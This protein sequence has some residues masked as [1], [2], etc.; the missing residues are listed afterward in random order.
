MRISIYIHDQYDATLK[1]FGDINDVTDRILKYCYDNNIDI[2]SI[3]KPPARDGARRMEINVFNEDYLNDYSIAPNSPKFS[4]RKILYWFVDNTI[5]EELDWKPINKF[6]DKKLALI[7]KSIKK[8]LNEIGRLQFE[9]NDDDVD[10]I[11]EARRLI[12][13]LENKYNDKCNE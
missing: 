13:N 4:L 7:N 3:P 2:A 1:M 11:K 12:K 8:L 6:I 9:V 5:Y 10:T